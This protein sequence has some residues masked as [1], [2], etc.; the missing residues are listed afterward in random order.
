MSAPKRKPS[1]L[2]QDYRY[3]EDAAA[4]ALEPAIPA[5]GTRRLEHALTY[6]E[7]ENGLLPYDQVARRAASRSRC[8]K[9][10][11]PCCCA[12]RCR[13][14]SRASRSS[15]AIPTGNR[16][17]Y[18]VGLDVFFQENLVPGAQ[19]TLEPTDQENVFALRFERTAAQEA[20]L[21][22]VRR[23]PQPLRLPPDHLLR[24]RQTPTR[25]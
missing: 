22:A 10:S 2:G 23:A 18:L 11:A 8:W 13:R 4:Q 24:R 7:Y 3:L 1:E 20:R 17:G 5:T 21:L 12:S 19:L 14:S 25:C 6:Y 16:G 9:I 15:Y